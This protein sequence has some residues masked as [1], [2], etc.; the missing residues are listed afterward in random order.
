[1]LPRYDILYEGLDFPSSESLTEM[2]VK[3]LNPP[4]R[5][6][7]KLRLVIVGVD[8]VQLLNKTKQIDGDGLGRLFLRLLRKSK[9]NSLRAIFCLC[10]LVLVSYWI[11]DGRLVGR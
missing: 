5:E 6:S 11:F 10:Q 7:K 1:M 4:A 8:E 2:L 3:N 9:L